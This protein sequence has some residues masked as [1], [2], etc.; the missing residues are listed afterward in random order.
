M[1]RPGEK[2]FAR[3]DSLNPTMAIS[4]CTRRCCT[5]AGVRMRGNTPQANTQVTDETPNGHR[6]DCQIK[7]ARKATAVCA[8][9][10]AHKNVR[11]DNQIVCSPSTPVYIP[12]PPARRT[13]G[14]QIFT[15]KRGKSSTEILA[16]CLLVYH[17]NRNVLRRKEVNFLS[18][19]S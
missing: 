2:E 15:L 18:C 5:N 4:L 11:V 13:R 10:R 12:P 8:I 19:E 17:V 1:A 3:L 16:L 7:R 14:R 9:L 6:V